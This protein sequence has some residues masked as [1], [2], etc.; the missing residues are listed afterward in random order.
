MDLYKIFEELPWVHQLA[1]ERFA[2]HAKIATACLASLAIK[3]GLS[4]KMITSIILYPIFL[5]NNF[6][7]KV[8]G[9]DDGDGRDNFCSN[10]YKQVDPT[11]GEKR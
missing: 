10:K 9:K 6:R 11:S 2:P 7:F 5:W 8:W 3:Q 4:G 1:T